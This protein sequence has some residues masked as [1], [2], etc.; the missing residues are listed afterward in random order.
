VVQGADR[1]QSFTADGKAMIVDSH[2]SG[3]DAFYARSVVDTSPER[4]LVVDPTSDVDYAQPAPGGT[5]LLYW[6]IQNGQVPSLMRA[7]FD[8]Q[9]VTGAAVTL[10]AATDIPTNLYERMRMRCPLRGTSCLLLWLPEVPTRWY[11]LDPRDGSR[12]PIADLPVPS[13]SDSPTMGVPPL[14]KY[15]VTPDGREVAIARDDTV[16]VF[17]LSGERPRH[18]RSIHVRLDDPTRDDVVHMTNTLGEA[19]WMLAYDA[20]GKGIYIGVPQGG[21]DYLTRDGRQLHLQTGTDGE[22]DSGFIVSPDGT[23]VA[24]QL[25]KTE[26]TL[27]SID[28]ALSGGSASP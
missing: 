15:D 11:R 21:I 6:R 27:W 19:L 14:A 24:Y 16:D 28:N 10:F 8:G 12:T 2:R 17:D 20:D 26:H 25:S 5:A 3:H 22:F 4:S 7:P 23:R 13:A 9:T 1:P 18:L